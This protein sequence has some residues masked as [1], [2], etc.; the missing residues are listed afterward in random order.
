MSLAS[1]SHCGALSLAGE[2]PMP[3]KEPE[4]T[5][6]DPAPKELGFYAGDNGPYLTAD[7]AQ[8]FIDGHLGGKGEVTEV[9][10]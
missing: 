5:K 8:A 3:L 7:D 1:H 4:A 2:N 9:A 6:N 10:E